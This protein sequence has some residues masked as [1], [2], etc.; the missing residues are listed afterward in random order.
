MNQ[1]FAQ[2]W[3]E[4]CV[5]EREHTEETMEILVE[6]EEDADDPDALFGAA[7]VAELAELLPPAFAAGSDPSAWRSDLLLDLAPPF[8]VCHVDRVAMPTRR[9]ECGAASGRVGARLV[10]S[11]PRLASHA[12]AGTASAGQSIGGLGGWGKN[13]FGSTKNGLNRR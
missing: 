13:E 7:E 3:R 9:L 5:R 1:D 4:L 10:R 8:E 11:S 2:Q 12:C 6:A